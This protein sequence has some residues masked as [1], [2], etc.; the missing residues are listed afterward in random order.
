MGGSRSFPSAH[1]SGT[2]CVAS[3]FPGESL[4]NTRKMTSPEIRLRLQPLTGNLPVCSHPGQCS[5]Q[6][7]NSMLTIGDSERQLIFQYSNNRMSQQVKQLPT[8]TPRIPSIEKVTH[9][10]SALNTSGY[11]DIILKAAFQDW[12]PKISCP[13]LISLK[14]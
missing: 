13:A 11:T 10:A 2:Y 9:C 3:I 6:S 1:S 7:P 8:G 4:A 12:C 14:S 5:P